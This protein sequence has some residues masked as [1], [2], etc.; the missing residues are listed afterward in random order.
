M[1]WNYPIDAGNQ[2]LNPRSS[3]WQSANGAFTGNFSAAAFEAARGEDAL[4]ENASVGSASNHTDG[5][6]PSTVAQVRA[7]SLFYNHEYKTL[8]ARISCYSIFR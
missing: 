5:S 2:G 4:S 6:S 7:S 3:I 1:S 8:L